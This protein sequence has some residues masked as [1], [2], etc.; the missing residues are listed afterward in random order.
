VGRSWHRPLLPLPPGA[1]CGRQ[2]HP[3]DAVGFVT[4][5]SRLRHCFCGGATG[6][7]SRTV[8]RV[9]RIIGVIVLARVHDPAENG[10]RP[11]FLVDRL[12]PRGI[13]RA[14]PLGGWSGLDDEDA[15]VGVGLSRRWGRHGG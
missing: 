15:R 7:L 14:A 10:N 8:R 3:E 11:S 9:V 5:A 6:R 4:A 12:W 2:T 13:R 1:V